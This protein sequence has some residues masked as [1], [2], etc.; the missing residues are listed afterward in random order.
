MLVP[1]TVRLIE[2]DVKTEGL[3]FDPVKP[4]DGIIEQLGGK[5]VGEGDVF[6]VAEE[7]FV[8]TAGAVERA[9]QKELPLRDFNLSAART[10]FGDDGGD[11]F[12][13]NFV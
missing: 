2:G 11:L 8:V 9:A 1:D 7:P 4:G 10:A 6:P 5:R 3:L 12:A 13:G